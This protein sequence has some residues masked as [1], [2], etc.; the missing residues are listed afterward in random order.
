MKRSVIMTVIVTL[1]G[2]TVSPAY[3]QGSA[4]HTQP[5]TPPDTAQQVESNTDQAVPPTSDTSVEPVEEDADDSVTGFR[6]Q[7]V[8]AYEN[9][10]KAYLS[11]DWDTLE[12]VIRD[13]RRHQRFLGREQRS[14]IAY[15]QRTNSR[16]RPKWWHKCSNS[17]N[18][19]FQT[20]LWGRPLLANYMPTREL[21]AQSVR[22]KYQWRGRRRVP[23]DLEV[24]V[25]WKPGLVDNSTPASGKLSE[26]HGLKLGDVGEVIVWHELGHCYITNYLPMKHVLELYTDHGMLFSHLQEFYAD[27]TAL[28]H[29]SPRARRVVLM[30]RLNGLDYYDASEQH[31]RAS[32]AIGAI[33]LH[34]VLSNPEAWPSFHFPPAVPDQQVELNTIIYLY[35]HM[36]PQWSIAEA[37]AL[38]EL[39]QSFIKRSGERTLRDRGI[40]PLPN[41]LKF[42]LMAGRDHKLQEKRDQYV[43]QR[44]ESLIASG[45]ADTLEEDETYDPPVRRSL[46][47]GEEYHRDPEAL[48][49]DIPG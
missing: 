32:H 49:M 3:A 24:I 48:R 13:I 21:G 43:T 22:V 2:F 19:S 20:E 14:N 47:H 44:L 11:N 40:V 29:T 5:D 26:I 27:L 23:A 17:S 31:D 10:V 41:K 45:R 42:S 25:T 4:A 7:A 16:F 30:L 15:I 28:Y 39:A 35:E 46:G 8:K 18:I 34:E 33:V 38:R 9:L 37:R 36:D 6:V 12:T 1:F